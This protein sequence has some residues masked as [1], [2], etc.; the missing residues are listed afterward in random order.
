MP[1][2]CSKVTGSLL[3]SYDIYQTRFS[4]PVG[5]I[6]YNRL[7]FRIATGFSGSQCRYLFA[8][9]CI[10][11][12]KLNEAETALLP[13]NDVAQVPNGAAGYYLLGRVYQLSNRH[14][15]AVAYYNTALQLDP[16]MWCA[17]EELC[18]L[19]ADAE[20]QQ[21]LR[22]KQTGMSNLGGH[23]D[24]PQQLSKKA[25]DAFVASTPLEYKINAPKVGGEADR[26]TAMST[27]ADGKGVQV[28]YSPGGG[29]VWATPAAM[30]QESIPPP[31]PRANNARIRGSL[32]PTTTPHVLTAQ[33]EH[34]ESNK[35]TLPRKIL[36]EG[37]LRK[38]SS[39]LF[40]EPASVLK[41]LP[42]SRLARGSTINDTLSPSYLSEPALTITPGAQGVRSLEGQAQALA[43]LQ[44][45]AEANYLLSTFKCQEAVEAFHRIPSHH[46]QTGWVLTMLGK[47]YFELVDYYSAARMFQKAREVDPFRLQG[48]EIY[49][50]V[51][52]HMRKEV[53]LSTLAQEAVSL[54]R[55]SPVTWCIM[56]NCFSLQKEHD[57]ALRFFQRALQLDSTFPYAYTLCGHE[58]FANEDFEKG[59]ACY[60]NAM[61]LDPRHYNAWF[62]MGHIYLRQE[63][64]GMAEYHFRRACHINP[65]SS[66][67]RCYLGMA[68]HKLKRTSDA[69]EALDSAIVADPCNPLA[70]FER[71]SVLITEGHF[72]AALIEL[73]NLLNI[74]PREAS[75]YYQ[76]GKVLKRLG[77]MQDALE[78][79]CDAL[80]LQPPSADTNV[81][82]AA[83]DRITVPDAEEDEEM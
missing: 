41:Q 58:Y 81:I 53:E 40:A 2:I 14:N 28:I 36:D 66:V 27:G 56:G 63:K 7:Y 74:A 69:L 76:M 78:A 10:E 31:A 33:W 62:G 24:D 22:A 79:F 18:T 29:S 54:D 82:K 35:N 6:H 16:M 51:L 68:L 39:K 17:H 77:K 52:W 37:K 83:I 30:A 44:L 26:T 42:Q 70:R 15:I 47:A 1:I 67:L 3:F 21:Y 73:K 46:M 32:I 75:V 48:L 49:S 4:F 55:L 13:E 25:D 20:A 72:D 57:S 12:G 23:N 8:K 45:L 65:C 71:A 34:V 59:I 64:F 43:L 11:L 50:T 9:C 19:G 60:R 80:D 38:V 61:R 5:C